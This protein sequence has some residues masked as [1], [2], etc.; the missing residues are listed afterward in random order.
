MQK[1]INFDDVVKENLK[2][3]DPH[4]PPIADNLYIILITGVSES[5]KTNSLSTLIG[6]QA[7]IDKS[8]LYAK[9]HWE[10]KCQLLINKQENT[11]L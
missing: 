9:D 8:Y 2:K 7:G 1:I 10:A 3:R 4:W 6:Q 11:D 5:W